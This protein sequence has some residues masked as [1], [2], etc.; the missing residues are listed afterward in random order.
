MKIALLINFIPPYH[1]PLFNEL[2]K[3][4]DR[5]HIFVSTTVEA[6]R[7]WQV[8]WQNLYV[9]KQKNITIRNY[10][11]HTM[12]FKDISYIHIPISTIFDLQ[13]D[14]P[15]AIITCEMGARTLNSLI[16]KFFHPSVK[17]ILWVPLSEHSEK[18]RG[19]IRKLLRKF[20]LSK[21]NAII[22]NGVSGKRYI[23]SYGVP[24]EKIFLKPYTTNIVPFLNFDIHKIGDVKRLLY[25]G[26]LIERKGILNFL[27]FFSKWMEKNHRLNVEFIVCGDGP[28]KD[29]ILNVTLPDNIKLI[30]KGGVAYSEIPSV[31]SQADIFVFPT[32]SDEWGLVVNEAM[33][34]GLPVLGSSYSQAV[35][36]LVQDNMNGWTFFPDIPHSIEDGINKMMNSSPDLLYE[37]GQRGR[38]KIKNYDTDYA[39]NSMKA[40][41]DYTLLQ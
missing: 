20:I 10:S 30:L 19:T 12:G 13:Q 27:K 18:S 4:V 26:Q 24:P 35:E 31:F 33:A 22:V 9:T 11:K 39:V 8:D 37:F 16:Y 3:S 34:A 38:E 14:L 36:E 25:V 40:A 5:F 1:V 23:E 6:N 41:I 32:L 21:V 15:D 28:L 2:S 29:Q 7:N 17:I